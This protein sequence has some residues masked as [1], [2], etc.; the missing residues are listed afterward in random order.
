MIEKRNN[1]VFD[2]IIVGSLVLLN[3]SPGED[4]SRWGSQEVRESSETGI[5]DNVYVK[6][7]SKNGEAWIRKEGKRNDGKL[8][9]IVLEN[10]K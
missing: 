9:K 6:V 7:T 8:H 2:L 5:K 1:V 10:T 4:K 3:K